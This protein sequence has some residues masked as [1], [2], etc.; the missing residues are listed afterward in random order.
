[1][2]VACVQHDP[3]PALNGRRP[4]SSE[5]PALR[6]VPKAELD[7]DRYTGEVTKAVAFVAKTFRLSAGEAEELE[8]DMWVRLLDREAR[9]LRSFRGR[10]RIGTYLVKIARNLLLDRRNKEW[11][12]W[13]P[14]A[15]ARRTGAVGEALDRLL[16]RDGW[17]LD[18]AEQSLKCSGMVPKGVSLNSLAAVLPVRQKRMFVDVDVLKSIAS[19]VQEQPGSCSLERVRAAGGLQRALDSVLGTLSAADRQLVAWRFVDGLTIAAI[20]PLVRVEARTLYRTFR[21]AP[22]SASASDGSSGCG[23]RHRRSML[24][25]TMHGLE[26][27]LRGPRPMATRF[28]RK[29][30]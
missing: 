11:G 10:A 21:E 9:V 8:S 27:D 5:R 18:A 1:M 20:A 6:I 3:R 24:S 22:V 16:S 14:S 17:S 13:R 28:E 12:R 15:A 19:N 7:L 26:C 4:S 29:L 2:S 23:F 30:A 25:E